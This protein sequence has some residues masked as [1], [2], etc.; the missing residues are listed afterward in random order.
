MFTILSKGHSYKLLMEQHQHYRWDKTTSKEML[1]FLSTSCVKSEITLQMTCIESTDAFVTSSTRT[2]PTLVVSRDT[3]NSTT[4]TN[5]KKQYSIGTK[6]SQFC[7]PLMLWFKLLW[8]TESTNS[9]T[10]QQH[11]HIQYWKCN[12]N[13][14]QYFNKE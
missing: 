7:E 11:C 5:I 8:T 9:L 13:S 1:T 4:L 6:P 12:H 10:Q 3:L 14:A 2:K